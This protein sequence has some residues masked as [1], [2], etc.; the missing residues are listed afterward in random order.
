MKK[1]NIL[2]IILISALQVQAQLPDTFR[3]Q[4]VVKTDAG[5]LLASQN[6]SFRFEIFSN[7]V[8]E[9]GG[10]KIY[11]ETHQVT[12]NAKG[13]AD[14]SIGQGI[15]E[16]GTFATID[17]STGTY[18]IRISIN[19]GSGFVTIGEQ[20]LLSTPYVQMANSA[21][22]IVKTATDD[23][24]WGLS[25][26]NTG[27]LTTFP[28]PKGYT[29]LVW[30]DE[31]DGT[32]LPDDTKWGYEKGYVRSSELQYYAEKRIENS[33]Q[34]GGLLHIVARQDSSIIDGE[35][36]PMSSASVIT[37][38]KAAWLYG[39]VEVRA[40][41]PYMAGIGTW[42]AIWMMPRDDFYGGWPRSGEIDI[43]EYVASDYRYV[44]FSQHSYKYTNENGANLHKTAKRYC[45]TA[46]TEF[47]TYGLQWT[48]ETM[49]WYLDGV[50]KYRVNNLEHLWS[51]WPFNKPFYLFLNLAM[52]GW[53]G[54]TNTQ[55]LRDNPQ[56]Y[57]I[58]YVRVFQ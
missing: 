37:K 34:Q 28:F 44:H 1:I 35:M 36:R 58:D 40:K 29:K 19:K 39:Y 21:G 45:P 51:S 42:P 23:T 15:A 10:T 41:V 3:Y 54:T 18:Y 38:G 32:G 46:Y 4:A 13:V 5:A 31:F 53:G 25:I 7:T 50:E 16:Q 22:N 2:I 12:T 11:S 48:P 27:V 57:Q 14:L 24:T 52:G 55:L 47:H 49:V 17:W 33:Y 20:Q 43:L 6:V 56:D 8:E 30:N 26:N 9:Y